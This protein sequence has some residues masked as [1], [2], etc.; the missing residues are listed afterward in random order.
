MGIN[1]DTRILKVFIENAKNH[2]YFEKGVAELGDEEYIKRHRYF[3]K[4]KFHKFLPNLQNK[5]RIVLCSLSDSE[6][7]ENPSGTYSPVRQS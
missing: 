7:R 5:D 2:R 3:D 6:K 4:L 1:K